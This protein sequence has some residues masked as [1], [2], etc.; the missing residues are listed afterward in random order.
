MIK[1]SC[2]VILVAFY[3]L[4]HPDMGER[5]NDCWTH[6]AWISKKNSECYIIFCFLYLS[7]KKILTNDTTN[8]FS[9]CGTDRRLSRTAMAMT[10]LH[11]VWIE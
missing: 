8:P 9:F 11:D 2:N 10:S 5:G 4:L 6:L 3:P 1:N 7:Q